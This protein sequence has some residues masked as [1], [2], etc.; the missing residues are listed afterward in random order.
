MSHRAGSSCCSHTPMAESP[1]RVGRGCLTG[2]WRARD[3]KWPNLRGA[4]TLER[5]MAAGS[6]LWVT[7]WTVQTP[8]GTEWLSLVL[9]VAG[10]GGR[11][12]SSRRAAQ[13]G[14]TTELP[15]GSE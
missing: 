5:D 15:L 4:I 3:N 7:A 10:K 8:D 2:Q 11:A 12:R 13:Q 14:K 1:K 6:R 9:D